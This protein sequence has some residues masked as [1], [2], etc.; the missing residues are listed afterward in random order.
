MER[1]RDLEQLRAEV[2]ES[3]QDKKATNLSDPSVKATSSR[4]LLWAEKAKSL[5]KAQAILRSLQFE[6][7]LHRR[8]GI[9]EAEPYT[10]QWIAKPELKFLDWLSSDNGVYWVTGDPG[11]G[12]STLMKYLSR[13]SLTQERLREW[14]GR[15]TLVRAS[16]YF[17]FTGSSLQKSQQ[18]LLRSLLFEILRQCPSL[19]PT[20]CHARWMSEFPT[21]SWTRIELMDTIKRLSLTSSSFK[22]FFLIDGLDEYQ[23][24]DGAAQSLDGD[25]VAAHVRDIIEAMDILT[26]LE[27]VKVC[28]SSR[29]WP[30]FE[31]A[32]GQTPDRKLYVHDENRDDIRMYIR[33]R[34]ERRLDFSNLTYE[35]PELLNL[36][37]T[38]VEDSR[39]VFLWVFLAVESL[40]RGLRNDDRIS[41]LRRRLERTP[42][43]LHDMFKRM[44]D[45][46]EEVYQEQAAKVL[47]IALHAKRPLYVA[48]YS[49][50]DNDDSETSLEK[51]ALDHKEW[52]EEECI[53]TSKIG[54]RR[55]KIRCPDLIKVSGVADEM[56]TA[57]KMRGHRVEFLHRTV[58]DFLVLE[59]SQIMLRQRMKKHFDPHLFIAKALLV[60]IG[61]A[62]RSGPTT[63]RKAE[64]G[65]DL[66]ELLY[67]LTRYIADVEER[68][69]I[70]QT[71]ILDQLE[72][73]IAIQTGTADFL[74]EGYS[75]TSYMVQ[76]TLIR[77]VKTR[78]PLGMDGGGGIPLLESA[79]FVD[80]PKDDDSDRRLEMPP[81][82]R[83][84]KLRSP[85]RRY[86][87]RS[88]VAMITMLLDHGA[89]PNEISSDGQ[90]SIWYNYLIQLYKIRFILKDRSR[91]H[92]VSTY[93]A[94][95]QCL[96]EHGADP[97]LKCKVGSTDSRAGLWSVPG[98]EYPIY[99]DV[100][101]IC[102]E[103]LADEDVEY[104][105]LLI[106]SKTNN[107]NLLSPFNWLG[108]LRS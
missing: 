50:V 59:E 20:I 99:K 56:K 103:I 39:G 68:L 47:Q 105:E 9:A 51:L 80:W 106:N 40:L 72:K 29:P 67:D 76:A 28:L 82:F 15:K 88:S 13:H 41:E 71:V 16:F 74:L 89:D 10:F 66:L 95:I 30:D 65:L 23:G 104:I 96:L 48:L 46:V 85:F 36:V 108:W 37:D 62:K 81:A 27:D 34:F 32:F 60:Q 4:L 19:I 92:A 52:S 69:D 93:S 6:G 58:R 91:D 97:T 35:V 17:W 12:K 78:L 49:L 18:G 75:F 61:A 3:I 25:S 14:A 43:R 102:R 5:E 57:Q 42:K 73:T 8:E 84:W 21:D 54:E 86:F 44:L 26:N 77:Y 90:Q 2:R 7:M 87:P 33:E 38:M 63:W 31:T 83:P 98:M 100:L 53:R 45:S 101:A 79:L 22:F 94:I 1:S 70:A 11:S 55:I 24:D 107:N 64:A